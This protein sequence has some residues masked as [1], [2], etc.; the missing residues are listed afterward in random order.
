MKAEVV[1]VKGTITGEDYF[2]LLV[3]GEPI[4]LP[5]HRY[6]YDPETQK[7]DHVAAGAWFNDI[8]ARLNE[9]K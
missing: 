6:P 2:I 1:K 7:Q 3:D 4:K 5:E 8:A 9:V